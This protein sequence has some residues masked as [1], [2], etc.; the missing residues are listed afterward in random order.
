[1]EFNQADAN[2]GSI[3]IPTASLPANTLPNAPEKHPRGID[4][5]ESIFV[6]LMSDVNAVAGVPFMPATIA[7]VIQLPPNA[8]SM[9][10]IYGGMGFA[11][12]L[13]DPESLHVPG[14]LA[15][16]LVDYALVNLFLAAGFADIEGLGKQLAVLMGEVLIEELIALCADLINGTASVEE[17]VL[18][19]C[20]TV[21]ETGVGAVL[22]KFWGLVAAA[23]GTATLT[24]SIPVAGQIA[25]A[26]AVTIALVEL[27][28][29][30]IEVGLSPQLYRFHLAFTH[31][32][33]TSFDIDAAFLASWNGY[34]LYYKASYVFDTG[35]A[36]VL[37]AVDLTPSANGGKMTVTVQL[38]GIPYGGNVNI[39][40]GIYARQPGTPIGP[41]DLVAA[42][43]STGLV[44]NN[45]D[46]APAIALVYN[47]VPISATTIYLHDGKTGLDANGQHVWQTGLQGR[48]APAYLPPTGGQQPSLGD[49]RGITVRQSVGGRPGYVGFAREGLQQRLQSLRQRYPGTVRLC[50]HSEYRYLAEGGQFRRKQLRRGRRHAARLQPAF[51]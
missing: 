16:L 12:S 37:N 32:L 30:A 11:G 22:E 26:A 24:D 31:D 27:T 33:S 51:G 28:E 49:L 14:F 29:S 10:V 36:H 13:I 21:F 45:S 35:A 9:E 34:T 18:T 20:K 23:I 44:P 41:N 15:T 46:T 8:A 48:N 2:G 47:R 1:V 50:R 17:F 19:F 7:P 25:R 40:V 4:T 38:K 42:H 3:P 6:G 43:G 5:A 39:M